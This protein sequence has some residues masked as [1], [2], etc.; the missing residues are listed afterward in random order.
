MSSTG[1]LQ[2]LVP[3]KTGN[4]EAGGR[5][6]ASG[7]GDGS[8]RLRPDR[9]ERDGIIVDVPRD[10]ARLSASLEAL[11]QATREVENRA[12]SLQSA[13]DVAFAADAPAD[14]G[15]RAEDRSPPEAKAE[16]A[17]A[18]APNI[19][20]D[21]DPTDDDSAPA[22]PPV[23]SGDLTATLKLEAPEPAPVPKRDPAE[24]GIAAINASNISAA[25]AQVESDET[26]EALEA[27]SGLRERLAGV[28]FPLATGLEAQLRGY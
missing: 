2:A 6:F 3:Q 15:A 12:T 14:G 23:Q 8:G 24:D 10:L 27:A 11:S 1:A 5:T 22:S 9:S 26:D 16:S 19:E 25:E 28:P 17:S 20:D 4:S 18:E 13:L 7:T 21:V